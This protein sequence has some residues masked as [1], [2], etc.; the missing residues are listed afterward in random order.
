[1][2][3]IELLDSEP[4]SVEHWTRSTEYFHPTSHVNE[5]KKNEFNA[6]K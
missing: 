5:S 1:M 2:K 6:L 4:Y 3:E